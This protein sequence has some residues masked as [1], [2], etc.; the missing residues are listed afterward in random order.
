MNRRH[1]YLFRLILPLLLLPLLLACQRGD[2]AVD[3]LHRTADSLMQSRPDS[4]L[5]LLQACDS[6]GVSPVSAPVDAWPRRQRMRHELLRAKA[7]NKA[8]VNFTTDS[9]MRQVADYYDSLGTPNER[10]EA[11]YLLGC[12][13]RDLGEAPRAID[14]YLDAVNCAD[15]T[16]A[17]CDYWLM[18]SVYGQMANLY[19]QQLLL[20]YEIEAHQKACRYDLLASDTLWALHEQ[21]M[22]ACTYIL[23][24]KRDS[25]ELMLNDV[26]SHYKERGYEQEALLTSTMLMHIYMANAEKAGKLKALI[27]E[28]DSKSDDFDENHELHSKKRL[29]YRYK[30][31]WFEN[32]G[33]LDSAEYY[34]RK[35]YYRDMLLTEQNSMYVGLM[36]VFKKRHQ[37]DSI[38]KYAQLYCAVN[39]SSIAIKDREV[40]AQLAASYKYNSI[41]KES[42]RNAE[43]A[44]R[45]NLRFLLSTFLLLALIAITILLVHHYNRQRKLQRAKYMA[46]IAERT[47]L[48]NE[49][50]SLNTKDYDGIIARKEKEIEY[51]NGIIAEHH[52]AYRNVMLKDKLSAF[53]NSEIV[54]IINEKSDFRKGS[55][56]IT[57]DEWRELLSEFRKDMPAAYSLLKCLSPLQLYVCILLLLDYDESVIAI[58]RQTKPQTINTAKKRANEKLFNIDD[59]AS[60]SS[61]LKGA[62]TA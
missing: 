57:N 10:M 31:K 16:A 15:T 44:H 26:I 45:A 29:F 51:L 23:Q 59:S 30:G 58:L 25:A 20:S 7:M 13:Y 12:V 42:N 53:E 5:L 32:T 52:N 49:L 9:V 33:Q 48:R 47:K 24:N 1:Q 18:A 40:T 38:A 14:C 54:R 21:K 36:S 27:E 60:L 11:H 6:V 28:Y 37:P 50:D 8:Y 61:N 39:D 35:M 43:A 4:A 34:Y 2:P 17:D 19:H 41:Q 22:I 55:P 62:L 56:N 46:T 3:A